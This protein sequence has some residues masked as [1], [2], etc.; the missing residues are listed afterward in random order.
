MKAE[1]AMVEVGARG[2]R[3]RERAT[4]R[5]DSVDFANKSHTDRE[6]ACC[7]ICTVPL[8]RGC[9]NMGGYNAAIMDASIHQSLS[10][11]EMLNH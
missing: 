4:Y 1:A 8:N 6:L 10:N 9:V 7:N 3:E 5:Q 11:R 2:E